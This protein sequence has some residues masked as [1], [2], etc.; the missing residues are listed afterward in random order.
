MGVAVKDGV[1][2]VA[3][4]RLFEAAA[5]QVGEDFERFPLDGLADRSIVKDA[6]PPL[7]FQTSQRGLELE[8]L[9]RV[10]PERTA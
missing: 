8:P 4:Q 3:E 5:S 10:P 1:H 7:C 9:R 2:R 6:D